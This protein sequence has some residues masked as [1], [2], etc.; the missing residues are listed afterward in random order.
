MGMDDAIHRLLGVPP[1]G[2]PPLTVDEIDSLLRTKS[3][4]EWN[5]SVTAIEDA[6]GGHSPPDWW[7]KVQLT[8]LHAL[9]VRS[10]A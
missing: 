7:E 8:G 1:T 4:R 6:R 10:W 5:A 2:T 9:V 3:E